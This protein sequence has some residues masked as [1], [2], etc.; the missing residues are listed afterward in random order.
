MS[1]ESRNRMTRWIA[2]AGLAFAILLAGLAVAA[3]SD[4]L[5]DRGQVLTAG[6]TWFVA[7]LI[8]WTSLPMIGHA[9]EH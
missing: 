5:F 1:L 2:R 9:L 4:W 6:V 8:M 3:G 7:W